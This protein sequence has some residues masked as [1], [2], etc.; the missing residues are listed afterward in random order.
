LA[1]KIRRCASAPFE[2]WPGRSAGAKAGAAFRIS[3]ESA[4]GGQAGARG[5]A[6]SL[7]IAGERT[8]VV[9]A[10]GATG[11]GRE[12]RLVPRRDGHCG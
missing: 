1:R 2:V 11:S 5:G 3:V 10:R 9:T 12:F 7:I 6:R 4:G 8:A